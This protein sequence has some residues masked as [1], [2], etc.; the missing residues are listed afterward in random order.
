MRDSLLTLV[1]YTAGATFLVGFAR[2]IMLWARTPVP[3]RIPTTAGQ[4]DSLRFLPRA[5]FESP[6]S[7]REVAVRL[8]LE[9]LLF[10]S[11]FRNTGHRRGPDGRLAYPADK[12]LWLAAVVFHWSLLVILVRHTR[13][14]VDP[15]LPF[16]GT[17]AALDGF[18]RV[19]IPSWYVTDVLV[20]ASLVWLLVRRLRHPLLRHLS[21]PADYLALGLLLA[22]V[23]SGL[24]M[25]YVARPDLVAV[26]AFAVGLAVFRP[27]PSPASAWLT[28]HLL[29]VGSLLA[30]LP[31]TKLMHGAAALLAPTRALANDSRRRRHVNPWNAPVPVHTYAEW[32]DAFRDK[33]LAARLPLDAGPDLRCQTVQNVASQDLTP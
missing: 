28:V 15:A 32:E 26:K 24:L 23:G 22:I 27:V 13:F 14:V 18:F 16:V 12:S 3:F 4:Q 11:L 31:F 33:I 2:R 19:G 7:A 29:L 17:L 21:L 1:V 8:A 20:L 10:R 30:V 6:S 9:L 5:R 25:R